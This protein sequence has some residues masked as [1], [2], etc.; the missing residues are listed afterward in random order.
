MTCAERESPTASDRP[1]G[2][3][4]PV[5]VGRLDRTEVVGRRHGDLSVGEPAPQ[6]AVLDLAGHLD[7]RPVGQPAVQTASFVGQVEPSVARD[8]DRRQVNGDWMLQ[9]SPFDRSEVDPT[10]RDH[11]W[12]IIRKSDRP[13]WAS[14]PMIV[15]APPLQRSHAGGAGDQRG[16][17]DGVT[18]L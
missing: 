11:G 5:E 13:E 7:E 6:R 17:R 15:V 12:R 8:A 2:H 3:G 14:R 18:R 16:I 10:E 9:R 4:S 1:S